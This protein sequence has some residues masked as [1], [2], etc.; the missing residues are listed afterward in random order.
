MRKG[1]SQLTHGGHP[2][3]VSEIRL[4]FAQ[5]LPLSLRLP[6]VGDVDYGT[7]IFNEIAER[8]ENGMTKRASIPDFSAG[9]NDAVIEFELLLFT[10][11]SLNHCGN[12]GLIV[13]MN[14]LK[15]LFIS[16]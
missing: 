13:W 5:P 14:G 10:H 11:R 12:S 1:C 3:D 7:H 15:E 6:A 16:G 8:V 4:R 2:A 9:M